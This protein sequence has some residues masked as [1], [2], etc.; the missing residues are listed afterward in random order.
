MIALARAA[1]I[2]AGEIIRA[3]HAPSVRHK[4][5]VDLVTQVDLA[6]ER[7]IRDMLERE[8][9][10]IPILA[11][12]GGGPD[13]AATRWIVDPLDGTTNFVH[14]FPFYCVSIALESNGVLEHAVV[15]DASRNCTYQASRGKG[16]WLEDQQLQVSNCKDLEQ[17]LVGSGFS[18]DR[19]ERADFYLSYLKAFLIRAQGFRR[20]GAAA[21]DLAMLAS[22]Q[23]DGFWEFELNAWDMAAGVLLIEE[24]GGRV[25]DM[26]LS[27]FD[28]Q[29]KRILASNE[30]IHEEMAAV[31]A[32]LLGSP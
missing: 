21:L 8:T 29:S 23:L 22:G 17:A 11:E 20:A 15:H 1:A 26:D 16:A 5:R 28:L 25:T 19:R 24:A 4:G 6:C 27:P 7:A 9:P 13:S 30:F 31:I 12:E 32:P 18:Y 14:G 3:S 10:N 2:Q